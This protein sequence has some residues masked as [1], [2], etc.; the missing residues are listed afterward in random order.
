MNFVIET[1]LHSTP[2][3]GPVLKTRLPTDMIEVFN[4]SLKTKEEDKAIMQSGRLKDNH[5]IVAL[6]HGLL[7]EAGFK[8]CNN[9]GILE[10][11]SYKPAL[12]DAPVK[13]PLAIHQDNFGA[14]DWEVATC[15]FYTRKDPSI[16]GGN[17][18]VFDEAPGFFDWLRDCFG[19]K[20]EALKIEVQV[21]TGLV[22]LMSGDVYHKPQDV[23][24][25]G[26]RDCIVV[27]L[28][29]C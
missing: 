25:V 26:T 18:E 12:N 17:I 8:V 3:H 28:R 19:F 24:G 15:I 29:C 7:T 14:T 23:F 5:V 21:S 6:A 13:T 16:Q 11:H 9:Q 22:L 20:T 1:V 2:D 4:K 27:Q 10:R